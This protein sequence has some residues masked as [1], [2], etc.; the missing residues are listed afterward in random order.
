MRR[1]VCAAVAATIWIL[2]GSGCA[3]WRAPD[4]HYVTEPLPLPERPVLPR[5]TEDDLMCLSDDAYARLMLRD[6]R[7]RQYAEE[8]ESIIRATHQDPA[9]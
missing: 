8:L 3:P 7:R 4:V 9:P 1:H 5:L 2:T 6:L